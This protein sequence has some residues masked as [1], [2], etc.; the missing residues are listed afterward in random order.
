[1]NAYFEQQNNI[2]KL[3]SYNTYM[4][5]I[6]ISDLSA[7]H[8]IND[9]VG[10]TTQKQMYKMI[11]Y[12]CGAYTAFQYRKAR[13]FYRKTALKNNVAGYYLFCNDYVAVD[14]FDEKH[15]CVKTIRHYFKNNETIETR[16]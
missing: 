8:C 12:F 9:Y 1:M 2:I 6:D 5:V 16:Y 15:T 14:I 3:Y 11:Q 13:D 4:G 10:T 7:V